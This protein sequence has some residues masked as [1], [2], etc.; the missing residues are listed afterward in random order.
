M[1]NK[2]N[3]KKALDELNIQLLPN[4]AQITLKLG[5][6]HTTLI[7][8]H[9]GICTSC[10]SATSQYHKLLTDMQEEILITQIN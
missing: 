5:L 10:A 2:D 1:V 8:Q 6:Q 7:Q 4:Y 3:M 9:Q